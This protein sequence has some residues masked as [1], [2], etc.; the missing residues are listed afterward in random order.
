MGPRLNTAASAV[1]S[2]KDWDIQDRIS[3]DRSRR[4][5]LAPPFAGKVGGFWHDGGVTDGPT[6]VCAAPVLQIKTVRGLQVITASR[7]AAY[8]TDRGH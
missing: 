6:A 1:P 7:S 2:A 8:S 4:K 5:E 3:E